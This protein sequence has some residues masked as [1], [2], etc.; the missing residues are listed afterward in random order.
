[1][2]HKALYFLIVRGF[3]QLISLKVNN[4]FLALQSGVTPVISGL[5]QYLFIVNSTQHFKLSAPASPGPGGEQHSSYRRHEIS[6]I[7]L[8]L[9]STRL[10]QQQF[11]LTPSSCPGQAQ[12]D[13]PGCSWPW[14]QTQSPISI[15]KC[16]LLIGPLISSDL[17]DQYTLNNC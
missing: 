12:S 8:S 9:I 16:G 2:P 6:V 7:I 14:L 17:T 11:P 10:Q 4:C 13:W 1:M 3:F 5:K 15:D